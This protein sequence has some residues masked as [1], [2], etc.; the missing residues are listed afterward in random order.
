MK[1]DN[2]MR[3]LKGGKPSAKIRGRSAPKRGGAAR[4]KTTVGDVMVP[5]V[6]TINP[7]ESL[8][9]AARTME[10]ANVGM[11]PVIENGRLRGVITDRD[12]VI[13]AVG[14]DADVSSTR[15]GECLTRHVICARPQWTTDQAMQAMSE[16]QVGRLP[17][18]DGQDQLVG[19]VT[20]S[21]M[22]FRAPDKG[23]ALEAAQE[24]SRRSARAAA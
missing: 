20:L 5:D 12:I 2:P 23:E 3:I 24:V 9:S 8:A 16:A 22:A 13:R 11:L 1:K 4:G 18:V 14:R 21:S 15:V 7:S 17:V 19:V 6:V 10:E